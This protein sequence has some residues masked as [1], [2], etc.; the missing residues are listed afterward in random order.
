MNS[1]NLNENTSAGHLIDHEYC[2]LCG[3]RN[4]LSQQLNF[5]IQSDGSVSTVLELHKYMQG[6]TGILHG[7]VMAALLDAAMT[8]CLFHNGI[9]GLTCELKV[10]Y[11][12]SVPIGDQ[13]LIRA[14]VV[15]KTPRL[16]LLKSEAILTGKV[17]VWAEGKFLS[18]KPLDKTCN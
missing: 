4:P 2:L 13:L 14:F 9:Q 8:H 16:F 11:V 7:G 6:Y 15:K 18:R 1:E 17:A 10:R 5:Q 3:S 12:R